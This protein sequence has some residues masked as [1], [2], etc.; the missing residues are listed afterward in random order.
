MYAGLNWN[1]IFVYLYK[2]IYV[3]MTSN[4]HG[5]KWYPPRVFFCSYGYGT[6]L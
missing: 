2:F 1:Q 3:L 4:W 5:A 6:R